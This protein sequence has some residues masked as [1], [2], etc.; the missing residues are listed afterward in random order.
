MCELRTKQNPLG[1]YNRWVAT[2]DVKGDDS[3]LQIKA[4]DI[5]VG[6]EDKE[7]G[8]ISAIN[9]SNPTKQG[10]NFICCFFL[11]I[12]MTILS[13]KHNTNKVIFT[14]AMANQCLGVV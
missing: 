12:S 11:F 13:Y 6:M 10:T 2:T 1:I 3:C 5:I 4:G 14:Q 7:G 9:V 8:C